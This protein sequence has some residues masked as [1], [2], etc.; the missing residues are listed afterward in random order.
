MIA[1]EENAVVQPDGHLV[2]QHPALKAGDQV[3]VIV[4]LNI[5]GGTGA[6]APEGSTLRQDWAGGL[7]NLAGEYS[8]VELQHRAR[9]WRSID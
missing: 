6:P 1:I 3:R 5:E 8:S 2:L 9:D 4:L 7:A